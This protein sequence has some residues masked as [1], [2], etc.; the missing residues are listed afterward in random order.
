MG[1]V[2]A[3]VNSPRVEMRGMVIRGRVPETCAC[4]APRYRFV[5]FEQ[6][7]G[8]GR[9]ARHRCACGVEELVRVP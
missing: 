5:Q 9:V 7:A 6:V 4:G 2:N 1:A 8:F 3:V